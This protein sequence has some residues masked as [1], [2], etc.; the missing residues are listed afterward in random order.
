[1]NYKKAAYLVMGVL[2]AAALIVFAAYK[3]KSTSPA[4]QQQTPETNVVPQ[5]TTFG[6]SLPTDFPTDIP[7]EKGIKFEQ[8]YS[9]NYVGQKQL[10][11]VFPSVKTV[12]ENYA[13]YTD[14]LKKQNWNISNKYESE[15]LSSL[16]GTKGTFDINVTIDKNIAA[17]IQSQ[18]SVSMLKK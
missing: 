11:I 6:A 12:K 10:T 4:S 2:A 1:M 14:F 8:S 5:K 3:Q 16:Y 13:L 7:V 17:P 18:V 15:E 9:L